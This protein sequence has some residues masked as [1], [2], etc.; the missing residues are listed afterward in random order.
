MQRIIADFNRLGMMGEE[1]VLP[2][3]HRRVGQ[4]TGARGDHAIFCELAS[5]EAEGTL[6]LRK[7]AGRPDWY[8]V[9]DLATLRHFDDQLLE[10]SSH[11]G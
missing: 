1:N 5:L 7:T 9:L 8:A 6:D 3:G 11:A 10:A 2:V 4:L